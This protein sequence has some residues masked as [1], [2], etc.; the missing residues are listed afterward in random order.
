M[1]YIIEKNSL[2][3]LTQKISATNFDSCS[4]VY[5]TW[6]FF[7]A[8]YTWKLT[9]NIARI[10]FFWSLRDF[11]TNQIP[12]GNWHK[13]TVHI[14][15]ENLINSIHANRFI[16]QTG[17]KFGSISS[18]LGGNRRTHERVLSPKIYLCLSAIWKKFF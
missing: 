10:Q 11:S 18:N 14:S 5:L 1:C 3:Y 17:G 6:L 2:K 15:T 13:V 8:I 7:S 9:S 4:S 12:Q 16:F